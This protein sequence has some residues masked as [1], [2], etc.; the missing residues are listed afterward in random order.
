MP[1]LAAL[2]AL[3]VLA[4]CAESEPPDVSP[5]ED[6]GAYNMIDPVTAEVAQD[7]GPANGD[8][9]RT[10][11]A[12]Q[13]AQAFGPAGAELQFSLRCDAREVIMPNRPAQA[14]A[15]QPEQETPGS[16][17]LPHPRAGNTSAG[18]HPNP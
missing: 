7:A 6:D 13:P 5:A 14:E 8:W 11:Q 17:P 10:M 9:T 4:A 15:R 18:M 16:T 12:E 1:R 2:S 3:L